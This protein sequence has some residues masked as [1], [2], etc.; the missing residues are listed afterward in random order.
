M[1]FSKQAQQITKDWPRGTNKYYQ[2]F[3]HQQLQIYLPQYSIQIL[4][5][6]KI[7]QNLFTKMA[8]FT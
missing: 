7:D 1:E 6:W 4:I 5:A 2:N 8:W 3:F